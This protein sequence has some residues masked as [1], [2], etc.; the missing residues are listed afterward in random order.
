MKAIIMAGG[1]GTR[2]RPVSQNIPKPMVRLFDRPVLAH[3]LGLLKR[4]Q[5][6]DACLTLRFL[7]QSIIDHFGDGSAFGMRLTHQVEDVPLGTAGS[8]AACREF[9]GDEPVLVLSGD[10]VCDSWLSGQHG[11]GI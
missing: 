6:T 10:A 9:I 5:I 3:T 2:L 11:A 4:N 7:P 1:E 8:V